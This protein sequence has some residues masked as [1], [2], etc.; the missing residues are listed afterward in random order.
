MTLQAT[1]FN[2]SDKDLERILNVMSCAWTEGTL[3]TLRIQACSRGMFTVTRKASQRCNAHLQAQC[4]SHPSCL[5]GG[6]F[7]KQN[8]PQLCPRRQGLAHLHGSAWNM[9]EGELKTML[10]AAEKAHPQSAH[11][12]RSA[13]RTP[14]NHDSCQTPLNLDA[15]SMPPS[16]ACLT[17]CFY[18]AARLGEFTVR[19]LDAFDPVLH[20]TP[21]CLSTSR[22]RKV[23][24]SLSFI[25]E[26]QSECASAKSVLAKQDGDTDPVTALIHHRQLNSPPGNGHLFR[27]TTHNKDT[28]RY[29][30]NF[31]KSGT[32]ARR[33]WG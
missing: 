28:A 30:T 33:C 21:A 23:T 16:L 13:N 17:T 32:A 5:D 24:N 8:T 4:S 11:D 14:L 6:P 9:N 3:E 27:D 25:F 1:R 15:P 22:N 26:N 29:K 7:L 2:L 10:K 18:A 31:G 19:R 20:V 12:G